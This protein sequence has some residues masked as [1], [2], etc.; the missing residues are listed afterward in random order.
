MKTLIFLEPER[1]LHVILIRKERKYTRGYNPP[2]PFTK[3]KK[4]NELSTKGLF[5]S[6]VD[7]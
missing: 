3:K 5:G 7:S 1:A 2:P 4:Q 6:T